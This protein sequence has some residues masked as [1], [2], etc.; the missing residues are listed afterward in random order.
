MKQHYHP[1]AQFIAWLI[2]CF[3]DNFLYL[4]IALFAFT[5]G[6]QYTHYKHRVQLEERVF[7]AFGEGDYGLEINHYLQ[8]GEYEPTKL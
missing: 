5:G 2:H 8:T 6:A 7:E 1:L 4:L 3:D